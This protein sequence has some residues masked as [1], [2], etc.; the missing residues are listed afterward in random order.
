[1]DAHIGFTN[2]G[3]VFSLRTHERVVGA[4]GERTIKAHGL[5][6]ACARIGKASGQ[7]IVTKASAAIYAAVCQA[8]ITEYHRGIGRLDARIG[9]GVIDLVKGTHIL[10]AHI[11]FTNGCDVTE[12]TTCY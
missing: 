2:I 11:G 10:D 4:I 12:Y 7:A 8:T 9:G 5:I 6:I 1:M 3:V